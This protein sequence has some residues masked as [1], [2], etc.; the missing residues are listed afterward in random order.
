MKAY[1]RNIQLSNCCTCIR[2]FT[3][4]SCFAWQ[5]LYCRCL[6]LSHVSRLLCTFSLTALPRVRPPG[7]CG[8]W[9][10]VHCILTACKGYILS[11]TW[12]WS[13]ISQTCFSRNFI[14]LSGVCIHLAFSGYFTPYSF[15]VWFVG[16]C[17]DVLFLFCLAN[18]CLIYSLFT[19]AFLHQSYC[20]VIR[21][22]WW[23]HC[24][25]LLIILTTLVAL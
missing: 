5:R 15:L 14:S 17:H 25:N 9:H 24:N 10:S 23:L 19:V 13:W 7:Q 1:C 20:F 18:F 16:I 4:S 21:S 6:V 3:R 8:W 22:W 12:S 2:M 11:T